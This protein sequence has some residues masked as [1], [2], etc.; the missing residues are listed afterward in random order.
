MCQHLECCSHN[1]PE[2]V[3]MRFAHLEK[4]RVQE[5]DATERKRF[6]D[7]IWARIHSRIPLGVPADF[8]TVHIGGC[9]HKSRGGLSKPF[10]FS[11]L[12]A[13]AYGRCILGK[14]ELLALHV[15]AQSCAAVR[16][17]PPVV[18]VAMAKAKTVS[19]GFFFQ[20]VG[21]QCLI[22]PD[23]HYCFRF[24]KSCCSR[25]VPRTEW[26][27]LLQCGQDVL[28]CLANISV[29]VSRQCFIRCSIGFSN[30]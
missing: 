22:S 23:G 28:T 4:S 3:K 25:Q 9:S 13:V 6:F 16:Q 17:I 29:R 10:Y 21:T 5:T 19:K 20:C 15:D 18:P 24:F 1:C 14:Y 12:C 7:R 27:S 26:H 2:E 11:L 8:S 30:E